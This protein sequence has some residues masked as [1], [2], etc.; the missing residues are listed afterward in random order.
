M[1]LYMLSQCVHTCWV[2]M[3][4][5]AESMCSYIPSQYVCPCWVNVGIHAESMCLYMLGECVYT[6]W[7]NVFN[8]VDLMCLF[9]FQLVEYLNVINVTSSMEVK[10]VCVSMSRM[11]ISSRMSPVPCVENKWG[12][13][14]LHNIWSKSME[15]RMPSI[16]PFKINCAF[17]VTFDNL[18]YFSLNLFFGFKKRNSH[19]CEHWYY[20]ST[21]SI[22]CKEKLLPL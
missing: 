9:P 1:S 15:V 2:N 4:I 12:K 11:F 17:W 16:R 22:F 8:Y 19:E 21:L 6:C 13:S 10:S 14:G 5:H 20:F 3:F 18:V 7:I